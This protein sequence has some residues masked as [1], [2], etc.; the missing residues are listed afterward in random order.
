MLPN[1]LDRHG[2]GDLCG[3]GKAARPERRLIL[4]SVRSRLY[5]LGDLMP[6][7]AC[8]LL[9]IKKVTFCYA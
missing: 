5:S 6:M 2:S 1:F 7:F 3:N 8:T 4:F 9:R